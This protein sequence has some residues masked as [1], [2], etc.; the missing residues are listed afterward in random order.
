MKGTQCTQIKATI[1]TILKHNKD[2]KAFFEKPK[3]SLKVRKL[4]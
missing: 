2:R 4:K 1:F 3:A